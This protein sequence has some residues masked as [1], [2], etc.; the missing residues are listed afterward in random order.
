[1]HSPLSEKTSLKTTPPTPLIGGQLEQSKTVSELE[2]TESVPRTV[3]I[4]TPIRLSISYS[5]ESGWAS[6]FPPAKHQKSFPGPRGGSFLWMSLD[7]EASIPSASVQQPAY[8]HRLELNM[9]PS[10]HHE[11]A[12]VAMY[13]C[14]KVSIKSSNPTLGW[15]KR[16]FSTPSA[17][18]IHPQTAMQQLRRQKAFGMRLLPDLPTGPL[19]VGRDPQPVI[20]QSSPMSRTTSI[21]PF[22]PKHLSVKERADW[23][24]GKSTTFEQVTTQPVYD[25]CTDKYIVLTRTGQ[26]NGKYSRFMAILLYAGRPRIA[27]FM[28]PHNLDLNCFGADDSWLVTFAQIKDRLMIYLISRLRNCLVA[29]YQTSFMALKQ[30]VRIDSSSTAKAIKILVLLQDG[31]LRRLV[32]PNLQRELARFEG[33]AGLLPTFPIAEFEGV[34]DGPFEEVRWLGEFFV[35]RSQHSVFRL[36]SKFDIES[37]YSQPRSD[38]N[39][40]LLLKIDDGA[41]CVIFERDLLTGAV[42]LVV[43]DSADMKS[44]A[45]IRLPHQVNFPSSLLYLFN[46]SFE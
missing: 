22:D 4:T 18:V 33:S 39:E 21:V 6:E 35:A 10:G 19:Q 13:S 8:L 11:Q 42:E 46:R 34:S 12:A 5:S 29:A 36:S 23:I 17:T 28:A 27:A 40:L 30:I 3:E 2:A 1:M 31:S 20:W 9:S 43:I 32:L 44:I 26:V 16:L 41:V 24:E 15:F 38:V 37:I 7:E 25:Y 45:S 14:K